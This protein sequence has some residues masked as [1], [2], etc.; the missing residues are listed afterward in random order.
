MADTECPWKRHNSECK[1]Q[2]KLIDTLDKQRVQLYCWEEWLHSEIN[3]RDGSLTLAKCRSII[4][5]ICL[6]HGV[7]PPK[8][9]DG[10]GSKV[11][12]SLP[13]RIRLPVAYRERIS[14][15]HEAC[16]VLN[17]YNDPDNPPHGP[18][19]ARYLVTH[20]AEYIPDFTLAE[21]IK[22]ARKFGVE[23]A[24]AQVCKPP[25]LECVKPLLRQQ[26]LIQ[27]FR[28][29]AEDKEK[30]SRRMAQRSLMENKRMCI[31]L[32]KVQT[33][34]FPNGVPKRVVHHLRKFAMP[35]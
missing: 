27:G 10:R 26:K 14:T 3:E 17:V 32:R 8:V 4:E 23:I 11:A 5:K 7:M 6:R 18:I 25:K 22:S 29:L 13:S 1:E 24:N 9:I 2:C 31:V 20:L 34:V 15:V 30:E 21:L 35:A 33:R 19:F 12:T 28:L 16:H